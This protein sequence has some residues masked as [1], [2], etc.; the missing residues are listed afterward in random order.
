MRRT[1]RYYV[2]HEIKIILETRYRLEGIAKNVEKISEKWCGEMLGLFE[3]EEAEIGE[4]MF[5]EGVAEVYRKDGT[6]RRW[7][8]CCRECC[9]GETNVGERRNVEGSIGVK[10]ISKDIEGIGREKMEKCSPEKIE[11]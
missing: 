2:I 9:Y 4:R 3:K 6:G 10:R 11:A 8:K 1:V 5:G 7:S